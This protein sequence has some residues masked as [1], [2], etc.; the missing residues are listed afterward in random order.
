MSS[1]NIK[2]GPNAMALALASSKGGKLSFGGGVVTAGS[3]Q[4]S[5]VMKRQLDLAKQMGLGSALPSDVVKKLQEKPR[6]GS[7]VRL[8][9]V[10]T[11]TP[12]G[13]PVNAE[14]TSL[15]CRVLI[16]TQKEFD[17]DPTMKY[18]S[19]PN[20]DIGIEFVV[21]AGKTQV[22]RAASLN[23]TRAKIRDE[24]KATL[25]KELIDSF[26]RF[27]T[28]DDSSVDSVV[29]KML[30]IRFGEVPAEKTK[31]TREMK[32]AREL[33][34]HTV[35]K[36][37]TL[38]KGVENKAQES[39]NEVLSKMGDQAT[40]DF[41]V[42]FTENSAE[43]KKKAF[44]VVQKIADER[45]EFA[46]SQ[47]IGEDVVFPEKPVFR[48]YA[49]KDNFF[50]LPKKDCA[51]VEEVVRIKTGLVKVTGLRMT[52]YV[53]P[54]KEG[55]KFKFDVPGGAP[56]VYPNANSAQLD[57]TPPATIVAAL[58]V[59]STLRPTE[60][61]PH[62]NHYLPD[63]WTM[64][65]EEEAA[66]EA[67]VKNGGKAGDVQKKIFTI[68]LSS[69]PERE[70]LVFP[71]GMITRFSLSDPE[72]LASGKDKDDKCSVLSGS[73]AVWQWRD[74]TPEKELEMFIPEKSEGFKFAI[75]MQVYSTKASE[76]G[77][78][79]LASS[80]M[81]APTAMTK[82]GS[83]LMDGFEGY[84]EFS[85]NFKNSMMVP[86]NIEGRHKF[87]TV[88]SEIMKAE[89]PPAFYLKIFP[90][91]FLCDW[92]RLLMRNCFP[93]SANGAKALLAG[94]VKYSA[95]SRCANPT[96]MAVALNEIPSD[97]VHKY[98]AA[99][100]KTRYQF[101]V[102]LPVRLDE[103]TRRLFRELREAAVNGWTGPLA[104]VLLDENYSASEAESFG[105]HP[106]LVQSE[107]SRAA[108]KEEDKSQQMYIFAIDSTAYEF[109]SS[110]EAIS[111]CLKNMFN[112]DLAELSASAAADEVPAAVEGA[113][114]PS[115]KR[116]P[117][118]EPEGEMDE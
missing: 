40:E 14:N 107:M 87:S 36:S 20:G 34:K 61:N 54:Q 60:D 108:V 43:A 91:N 70:R 69:E 6:D 32:A 94:A 59:L 8:V 51:G 10:G 116:K 45:L 82:L 113:S 25:R 83:F 109:A 96:N 22:D 111:D 37:M 48:L 53:R 29:D 66:V 55:P 17:A 33:F 74:P 62:V 64:A 49:N 100:G 52:Y 47:T 95:Y 118:G 56:A 97:M 112:V 63:L 30:S 72:K 58:N 80:P 23:S 75:D 71:S 89:A 106:L 93:V 98:F 24:Y 90:R 117:E 27:A 35:Q 28:V 57:S 67:A 101:E 78:S 38:Y 26:T 46:V 44:D 16:P 9:V 84:L 50:K 31:E 86:D 77:S 21:V 12:P 18:F 92:P 2:G 81:H 15:I 65:D 73:V 76:T 5:A 13:K 41:L 114:S 4:L 103:R 11:W 19:E 1:K 68:K 7:T 85:P 110:E 42:N 99:G 79:L 115:R 39:V 3:Q 105:A 102:L 104:E 88:A